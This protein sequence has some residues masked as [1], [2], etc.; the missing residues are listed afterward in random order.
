[1]CH[2]VINSCITYISMTTQI[3]YDLLSRTL[4]VIAVRKL[5]LSIYA[6]KTLLNGSVML[7][8]KTLVHHVG[9][10]LCSTNFTKLDINTDYVI[11]MKTPR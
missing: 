1:M 4:I 9:M 8:Q 7:S 3:G 2:V 10:Y 6:I 5:M 11:L